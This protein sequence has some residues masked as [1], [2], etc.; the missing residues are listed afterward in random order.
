[1]NNDYGSDQQ[2]DL[3]DAATTLKGTASTVK[4]TVSTVA[5]DLKAAAVQK[6]G[7]AVNEVKSQADDAK[8]NMA[9]EVKDVAN[10][11]RKASQD[12]RGGSAQERTLGQI[13][14][15]LADAS[16]ALRDKDMGEVIASI[17]AV[18][19]QNPMLFLGGAVVLGFAA[20]RFAK[21]S[22]AGPGGVRT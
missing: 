17:S 9:G 22:T 4:D 20:S 11:L 6:F 15:G 1:M 12:L 16:D 8:T 13:A 19:R 7:A 2:T 18:A 14:N 3:Q 5:S 21:A 10:A